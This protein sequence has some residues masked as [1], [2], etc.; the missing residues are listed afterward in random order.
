MTRYFW[1]FEWKRS[2]YANMRRKAAPSAKMAGEEETGWMDVGCWTQGLKKTSGPKITEEKWEIF[3]VYRASM[4][5]K[6]HAAW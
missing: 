6:M 2:T 5:D 4:C 3:Y 1:H